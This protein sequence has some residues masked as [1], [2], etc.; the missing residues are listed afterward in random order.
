MRVQAC[1]EDTLTPDQS[2]ALVERFEELGLPLLYDEL[3]QRILWPGSSG[4]EAWAQESPQEAAEDEQVRGAGWSW[5]VLLLGWLGLV[6]WVDGC[7][8][9]RCWFCVA[10]DVVGVNAMLFC[11]DPQH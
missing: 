11:A 10:Q 7:S 9:Q 4:Y 2:E 5:W 3:E 8:L 1:A 6:G